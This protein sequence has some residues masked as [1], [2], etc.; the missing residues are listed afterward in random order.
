MNE[1]DDIAGLK[2]PQANLAANASKMSIVG[3]LLVAA[4]LA[5]VVYYRV[6]R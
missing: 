6:R 2:D 1:L 4:I 5:T 3:V